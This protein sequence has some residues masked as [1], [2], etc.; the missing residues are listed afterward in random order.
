MITEETA[1]ILNQGVKFRFDK[2]RD[3]WVLLAPERMFALDET[4]TEIMKLADG[5]RTA[6][7]IAD[8]LAARFQAPR[9]LILADVI[10]FFQDLADKGTLRP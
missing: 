6:G 5:A 4:G 7:Q 1:P 2:V 9:E 10:G 3:A 8:D